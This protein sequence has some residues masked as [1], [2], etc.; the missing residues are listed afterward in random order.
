LGGEQPS[1]GTLLRELRIAKSLTIEGLSEASGVSVRGI[2]DLERGRR[3]APQ[4]RTVAA[5]AD[6]L[7]LADAQRELLLESARSGRSADY[8]PVGTQ[9][10]PRG[11]HDFVGRARELDRLA[12]LADAGTSE[13]AEKSHPAVVVVSGV[14]G[15]GK[16]TLALHA[17]W[18]NATAFG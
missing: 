17:G 1:F 5:L 14:P 16:T 13:A 3:A 11:V 4:R 8:C 2:G 7:E 15:A 10:L 18:P 12:E 6:G 9:A